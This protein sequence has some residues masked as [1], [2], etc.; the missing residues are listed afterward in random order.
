MDV[1]TTLSTSNIPGGVRGGR[2]VR[3]V[4][5]PPSVSRLSRKCGKLE[6]SQTYG[7][8]QPVI[9]LFFTEEL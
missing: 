7:P 8:P 9:V 6:V 3:L 1:I 5:S 2:G 4:T